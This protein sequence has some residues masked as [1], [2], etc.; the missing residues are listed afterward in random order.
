[1]QGSGSVETF[2]R[3]PACMQEDLDR[4]ASMETLSAAPVSAQKAGNKSQP[5]AAAEAI[6]KMQFEEW[7][8]CE[9]GLG[10]Y[11]V[12]VPTNRGFEQPPQKLL[13]I[14]RGEQS[15]SASPAK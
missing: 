8:V 15:M 4:T 5:G 1:M 14:L 2:E 6:V 9:D 12:H 10:E 7:Q 3:L 11:Y 13:H